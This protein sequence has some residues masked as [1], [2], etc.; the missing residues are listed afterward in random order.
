MLTKLV[1]VV[2]AVLAL[3]ILLIRFQTYN[4][5]PQTSVIKI[6]VEVLSE[7]YVRAEKLYFRA[8]KYLVE[9]NY[10]NLNFGDK[11]QIEGKIE[12]NK[13]KATKVDIQERNAFSSYFVNLRVKLNQQI[14]N[15]FPSP[16]AELL[17]GILLGIKSNLSREFKDDLVNTGTLH[18][19]VVSGYNISLVA[20]FFLSFAFLIG[21]RKASFLALLSIILYTLL[22]GA[23]PPTI[24][25]AIMGSLTI[26]ALIL[27][28]QVL[29]LYFLGLTAYI[30]V[31]LNPA[32][33][34][35]VS[36]QLTF[37]A[38]L[39]IVCLTRPLSRRLI[40][41]PKQVRES[42]SGT[43]AA[44]IL[45][46]PL[47]FYYFGN[48]SLLSPLV[49]VL[50]LWTVPISTILGFLY[51]GVSFISSFAA[52]LIGYILLVPLTIFTSIVTICGGLTVFVIK[53]DK[54]NPLF[55]LGYC[56]VLAAFILNSGLKR[57]GKA[58][59]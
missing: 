2:A 35:D 15:H 14:V 22:V 8:D 43:L 10:L 32:N 38:T 9:S 49:N 31:L 21:R 40:K 5:S 12:D 41:V 39:G 33:L 17:S 54:G 26:V 29:A 48:I 6:N 42:L 28:R 13:L 36:F 55:V 53:S 20:S 46:V 16:Q 24:R 30:M 18:V 1:W 19:V 44:Q 47:I 51:L 27:G 50:V 56:L 59:T 11:V 4:N 23:S 58:K 3:G 34:T 52:S 7:P 37:A 25:A 57:Y 45:V